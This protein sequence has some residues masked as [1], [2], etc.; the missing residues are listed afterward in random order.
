M[1]DMVALLENLPSPLDG[2]ASLVLLEHIPHVDTYLLGAAVLLLSLAFFQLHAF[3]RPPPV[4]LKR[5]PKRPTLHVLFKP[6]DI[7]QQHRQERGAASRGAQQMASGG[8]G[9]GG[10]S[11]GAAAGRAT[12][13]GGDSYDGRPL[14]ERRYGGGAG[15]ASE[16][17]T[18]SNNATGGRSAGGAGPS[19]DATA[20][21]ASSTTMPSSSGTIHHAIND[22]PDS[23]APLLSSSLMEVINQNLTA[24]LIHAV[25][26]EGSVRMRSGRH[27]IP[28]SRSSVKAGRPQFVLDVG[29]EGCKMTAT[30]AVGSD[31]LTNEEDLDVNRSTRS[32]SRPMVKYA[33]LVLDPPL[34]LANVAPT[35]IHFPT[36]FE[37]N[38]VPSL[39]RIQLVRYAFDLLV[40]FS[41]LLEKLLWIVESKCQI[42]LSKVK[43]SPFYK[44][45]WRLSLSFS[46][47]LL[48]FGWIPVPFIGIVLPTFIIPQPYAL[49]E[50]LMTAQPLASAK[51]RKDN[52]VEEERIALAALKAAGSW[53]GSVKAVA[54]PPAVGID[55]TVPGGLTVAVE[56][57]HGRDLFAGVRR[58]EGD[59]GPAMGRTLSAESLSSWASPSIGEHRSSHHPASSAKRRSTAFAPPLGHRNASMSTVPPPEAFDVNDLVPWLLELG[60][61]GRIEDDKVS[62]TVTKLA[63]SHESQSAR[64]GLA[65]SSK[66][67]VTGSVIISKADPAIAAAGAGPVASHISNLAQ[68]RKMPSSTHLAALTATASSPS[69]CEV[70][71]Y[72]NTSNGAS[73]SQRLNQFLAY[74]YAFDISDDTQLDAI[75]L[76]IGATHPLLKGGTLIT[77]VVETIYAYG[78][79]SAREGAVMDLTERRRKRNILRHLPAVDFTAGIN[80][81]FIPEESM[82]YSDDGQT[83]CIPELK[84][85]RMM[86]R[87]VGGFDRDPSQL[88]SGGIGDT[89]FGEDADLYVRE[90]VKFCVDF[91]ASSFS[92]DNQTNIH[93]FPELDILERSLMNVLLSGTFGGRIATHLRPQNIQLDASTGMA[94]NLLNPLEAYEID[95][96][97]SN[98]SLK[99]K[100]G[101]AMLG[102]RRV[103]CP[104]ETIVELK[105][106]ESVVDMSF[107]GQTECEVSWDFNGSSPIL[108]T[109]EVGKSPIDTSH[110]QRKQVEL[111]I[112]ELRQGRLNLQV[113]PVGGLSIQKAATSR[114]DREGLYDWRFFN[115]LVAPDEDSVTKILDVIHDKRS[116][117][118]LLAVLNIINK[119]LERLARYVLTRAWKAKDIFTKEGVDAPSKLIPGHR[120]ARLASLFLCGDVSQV[121]EILPIIQRVVAGNGLDV[122]RVKDLLRKNMETY[123][124]WAP[125][126]D[127]A[128]RWIDTAVSPMDA[129]KPYIEHHCPSLSELPSYQAHFGGIPSA[130]EIYDRLMEKQQLP[131]DAKVS[132]MISSCAP[133][134][135]LPQIEFV[136][137][138][139][140]RP[141][142]WMPEDLRRI[143]YVYSI[144]KKVQDISE[145]YGGLSFLP[146]SFF[147]SIFLGEATRASLRASRQSN[148][149]T[150][151]GPDEAPWPANESPGRRASTLTRL[152][153]RRV[154]APQPSYLPS[155]SERG[156]Y[157]SADHLTDEEFLSPAGRV[158][159]QNNIARRVRKSY[160]ASVDGPSEA[161]DAGEGGTAYDLG[162]SLLGPQDVA[163]LLQ[164]GLTS[165]MKGSTVVQLNQRMLL[166]L[167]ASQPR[168][169]AVA[170]LAEIG[171][172]GGQGSP[173]GL[174]SA[175]MTLLELDQ[176]SFTKFH[177]IDMHSLLE[178]V[179]TTYFLFLWQLIPGLVLLLTFSPF[180]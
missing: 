93:E 120:M 91:A 96:T 54:T 102:H 135:T 150:A 109:V 125:E 59:M 87:A 11:V 97:G 92:M 106:V 84:G 27:E 169:F 14:G 58:N 18:G 143:R 94:P 70:L 134:M 29:K 157:G 42:H 154:Y 79:L 118:R 132:S 46:G 52:L 13:G 111:L 4:P 131:L 88:S 51:L 21:T 41:S 77:T 174:C 65:T 171:T 130:R 107:E 23:F 142:D 129:Q 123:D 83:R 170:V 68:A 24:D 164:A 136:L 175:L 155:D 90:G 43:I 75:S 158:A 100:E 6:D 122:V 162:D 66:M 112:Y 40:A 63:L 25:Q 168:S 133:Y 126:I 144:K 117:K 9:G 156:Q 82:S 146:Q 57:M 26:F 50:R 115:A 137:T 145:S 178:S 153:R 176:S 149:G 167:M 62:L 76:S 22:L 141:S 148:R 32:R 128:V 2:V 1:I 38:I 47:H 172:P 61:K 180:H 81:I 20:T 44:G 152:R 74:D 7:S 121:E 3:S 19:D 95:F 110:E 161:S 67:S 160:R 159:S 89:S 114:E 108:Q 31:R 140:R 151:T 73:L 103:I 12:T 147:V 33:N 72:P 85:G 163:I 53:Q 37:D 8:G 124:E 138:A 116:M 34:P 39:R 10:L 98:A 80:N 78:S 179:S 173:R 99:L 127:R 105:I 104:T 49:L 69:V 28:L 17:V 119:D 165:S 166:D 56:M 5:L 36:L 30:A 177:R 71:L 86:I 60:V 48:L 139:R 101:S 35:L 16:S 113:S 55:L 64:E 15:S 45:D